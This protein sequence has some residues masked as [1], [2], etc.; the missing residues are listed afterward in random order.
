[1]N[2]PKFSWED[3]SKVPIIGIIRNLTFDEIKKI[4]PVYLEAGLTTIEITMNTASAKEIIRYAVD[5][6]GGKLN[7][8]AGTVCNKKDLKEALSAGAQ[9]IVT[10]ITDKEV[11]RTCIK[12]DIPIFPGAFT[13]TEIYKAWQLGASMVKLYPPTTMGPDYIK[14]IKAPLDKIKLLPTGGIHLGNIPLF[15][16]A[17]AN[18]V[19]VGSQ[20]FDKTAIKNNDMEA[21]KAH[22]E[23]FR[24]AVGQ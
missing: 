9:F 20:L 4:L 5:S 8:G 18:G 6:Y 2:S 17:G 14:D 16:K 13:P 3:F 24:A 12:E 7:I 19:G 23:K 21:L 11:I 10:P 15:M 22:F 1:M